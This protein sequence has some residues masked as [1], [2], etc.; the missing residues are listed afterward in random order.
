MDGIDKLDS[1][2]I[3][4]LASAVIER[5]CLLDSLLAKPNDDLE[6]GND[7]RPR[8]FGDFDRI[9]D[10]IEVAMG[11][12]DVVRLDGIDLNMAGERVRRNEGI[13]E[14]RLP[15]DLHRET[16]MAVV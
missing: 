8:A 7:G 10:V 4:C 14:K 16:R 6:V 9:I 15:S 1:S 13:E 2:E 12:Q 5:V 11:D 3:E